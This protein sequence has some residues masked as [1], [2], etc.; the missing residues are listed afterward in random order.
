[1][2]Y[3]N[4]ESQ[5]Y[6]MSKLALNALTKVQQNTFDADKSRKGIIVN[7]AYPG[8][9][10]TDKESDHLIAKQGNLINQANFTK[11]AKTTTFMRN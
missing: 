2:G 3:P 1:M 6:A 8:Y 5:A 10:K 7:S 11:K 4:S 9:C